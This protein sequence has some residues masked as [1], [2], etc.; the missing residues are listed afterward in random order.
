ME[1]RPQ[2]YLHMNKLQSKESNITIDAELAEE[3]Q[4]LS[5]KEAE[6]LI[7]KLGGLKKKNKSKN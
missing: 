6:E 5:N 3:L 4:G 2:A 7:K 1:E